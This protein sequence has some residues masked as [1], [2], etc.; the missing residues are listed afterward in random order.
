MEVKVRPERGSDYFP[1][2]DIYL[3]SFAD[4]FGP[5]EYVCETVLM[6][7]YRHAPTFDPELSLVAEV[8]GE[9]VGH[10]LFF[11]HPMK[12]SGENVQAVFLAMMGVLPRWQKQGIG[13]RLIS[14]GLDIARQ[15]GGD[16]SLVLGHSKYYP[17]FGY[18]PDMFGECWV[19]VEREN[20]VLPDN[21]EV[22]PVRAVHVPQL[23][24]MW[25]VWH[26]RSDLAIIPGDSIVDWATYAKHVAASVFMMDGH[27]CGYARYDRGNPQQPGCVLADSPGS[28]RAVLAWLLQRPEA[29]SAGQIK[30]PV[31]PDSAVAREWLEGKS[32][33][34]RWD[35]SMAMV[36]NPACRAAVDY[37]REVEAK[38]RPI[39]LMIWP[40]VV[41]SAE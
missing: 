35:A 21:L 36:L 22:A 23:Q 30:V 27:V 9:V 28:A 5:A 37:V 40:A 20:L 1:V 41:T 12:L 24:K 38:K 18:K 10:I 25:D 26:G 3:Q 13:G 7:I 34:R 2:A 32:H 14:T 29:H 6:D 39:G 33:T 8:D 19:E 31:H 11:P 17:R 15:K 4:V 16:I